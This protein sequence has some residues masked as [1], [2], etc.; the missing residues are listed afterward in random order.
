MN[1]TGVYMLR[2]LANGDT[3]IGASRNIKRRILGHLGRIQSG[4]HD[5]PRLQRS[6][7]SKN[8]ADVETVVLERCDVARLAEAEAEW[9]A[10]LRP[11]LNSPD[12]TTAHWRWATDRKLG[13]GIKR[14]VM[15]AL[16]IRN[17]VSRP[18]R[19]AFSID[20]D[21]SMDL[22]NEVEHLLQKLAT[23]VRRKHCRPRASA[24]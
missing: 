13:N 1:E 10:K 23:K 6:F 15:V 17:G 16:Y 3:Y 4:T 18:D 14:R 9:V 24:A 22:D 12:A 21:G 20:F 19:I 11:N 7:S 2:N 5:N 8:L